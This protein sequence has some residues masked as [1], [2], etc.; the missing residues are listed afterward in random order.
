MNVYDK[1]YELVRA[2]REC[3]EYKDMMAAR[4]EVE[5]DSESKRMLDDFRSRQMELQQ[6]MMGGE[7]PPEDE[8]KKMEQL[9]EVISLNASIR[10]L[11]DAERRL[12]VIVE[13]I[14]RIMA[15]PL[16]E[17]FPS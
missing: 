10:K 4:Q 14:Q 16:Q 17:L 6:K 1:A 9:F 15:E 11:F 5:A 12:S 2:L 3:P 13:D 8:L 7:M